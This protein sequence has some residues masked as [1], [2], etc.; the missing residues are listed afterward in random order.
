MKKAAAKPAKAEKTAK[1]DVVAEE[2]PVEVVEE[3]PEVDEAT[4]ETTEAPA[5]DAK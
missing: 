3:T 4:E 5:E 1:A 2:T